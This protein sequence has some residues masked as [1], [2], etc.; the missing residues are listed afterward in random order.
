MSIAGNLCIVTTC[1][2][3]VR[4]LSGIRKF[5][6]ASKSRAVLEE[7]ERERHHEKREE[8]SQHQRVLSSKRFEHLCCERGQSLRIMLA[9]WDIP[10]KR[11]NPAAKVLRSAEL[12]AIA[13]AA[14]GLKAST[15]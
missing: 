10:V 4:D 6:S 13:L 2:W 12:A 14:I 1:R 5:G 3:G 11:G 7:Y 9:V 8:R 15:R